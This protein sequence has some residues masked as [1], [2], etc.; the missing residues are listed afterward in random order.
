MIRNLNFGFAYLYIYLQMNV[1]TI[2]PVDTY[3]KNYQSIW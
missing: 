3:Y 2:C 1:K